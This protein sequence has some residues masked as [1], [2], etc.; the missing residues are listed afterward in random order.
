MSLSLITQT[1]IEARLAQ[2]LTI[3]AYSYYQEPNNEYLLSSA[4]RG[5]PLL[6]R[7]RSLNPAKLIEMWN[8]A[9]MYCFNDDL[10]YFTLH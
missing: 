1:L 5:W 4:K 6:T 2:C 3:S 9:Q 8:E 10:N 7:F